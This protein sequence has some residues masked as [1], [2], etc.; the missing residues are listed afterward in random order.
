MKIAL[1]HLLSQDIDEYRGLASCCIH[2][3]GF[4]SRIDSWGEFLELYHGMKREYRRKAEGIHQAR[5]KR[6]MDEARLF[7]NSRYPSKTE[8]TRR[9]RLKPAREAF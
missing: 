1:D 9:Y 5:R 4:R 6:D 8:R 2:I 7:R 3:P